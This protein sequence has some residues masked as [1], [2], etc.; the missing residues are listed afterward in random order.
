MIKNSGEKLAWIFKS[1]SLDPLAFGSCAPRKKNWLNIFKNV[2]LGPLPFRCPLSVLVHLCIYS[3]KYLDNFILYCLVENWVVLHRSSD[4][5]LCIS[6]ELGL[7]FICWNVN[8]FCV[9]ALLDERVV[10]ILLLWMKTCS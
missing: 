8:W 7:E 5:F 9:R 10:I 3:I 4:F 2:S 1:V 6:D